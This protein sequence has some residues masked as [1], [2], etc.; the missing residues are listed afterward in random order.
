MHG[1][2]KNGNSLLHLEE[3]SMNIQ[4]LLIDIYIK[5]YLFHQ[6]IQTFTGRIV[7]QSRVCVQDTVVYTIYMRLNETE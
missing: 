1:K 3:Y 4:L 7:E 6:D 2:I 5:V